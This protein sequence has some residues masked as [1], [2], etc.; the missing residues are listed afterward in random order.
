MVIEGV[1]CRSEL[2][3]SE[4]VSDETFPQTM[5]EE[6]KLDEVLDRV[7][8]AE[9]LKVQREQIHRNWCQIFIKIRLATVNWS[10]IFYITSVMMKSLVQLHLQ[11]Y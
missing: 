10:M 6:R 11:G 8:E 2:A 4:S 7:R 3:W 5:I 1:T 9:Q